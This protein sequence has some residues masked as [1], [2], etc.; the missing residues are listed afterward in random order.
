MNT[1]AM[2]IER[3]SGIFPVPE[4]TGTIEPDLLR[5]LS[6]TLRGRNGVVALSGALICFGISPRI[7]PLDLRWY[8]Q[9]WADRAVYKNIVATDMIFGCDVF[10]DLL[11]VRSG[12]IFRLDSE[13]GEV[14]HL[15][16]T[17]TRFGLISVREASELFGG[18]PARGA[19]S[20]IELGEDP[21]RLM[22]SV[23]FVVS[24]DRHDNY[25]SVPLTSLLRKKALLSVEIQNLRDGSVIDLSYWDEP[26]G[27]KYH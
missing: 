26:E 24:G 12:S 10:G 8:S 23:P 17:V 9:F 13:L 19:F 20:G 5:F 15:F 3:Q 7:G 21:L 6:D 25:R 2:E 11:F 16:K 1:L 27:K 14:E 22:P 18:V 4:G